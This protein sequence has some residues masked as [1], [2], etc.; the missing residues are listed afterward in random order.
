MPPTVI[1]DNDVPI[2][3]SG[4]SRR[5]IIPSSRLLDSNNGATPELSSHKNAQQ[6][7]Q[8]PSLGTGSSLGADLT[9]T[10]ANAKRNAADANCSSPSSD[11]LAELVGACN[12]T[13]RRKEKHLRRAGEPHSGA[14][15]IGNGNTDETPA[16]RNATTT[17]NEDFLPDID[18]QE[19]LT[20]LPV[21][22]EDK[23]RDVSAFFGKP[24]MHKVKDGKARTV[25]DCE[26]C[27][28]KGYPHQIVSDTSTCRR[29]IAYRHPDAY[30]QWCKANNFESML[31]QDVKERK[32]AAAIANAQQT[33]LDSHLEEIPPYKAVVP[34]TDALF[35]EEWWGVN[36]QQY[37]VWA[38]LA[39]NHLSIMATSV[40]SERAFSAAALTITKR[41]N[42]LKGD[43][44][45]AIQVLRMMYQ[46]DL[47]FREAAPS[48]ALELALDELDEGEENG[49]DS[50]I[51]L[52]EESDVEE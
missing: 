30:R 26:P 23:G 45:E 32:T 25:R 29:H 19:V 44:V 37:P 1:S 5:T 10:L 31:T 34:Y 4:R 24:Y 49:G 9:R 28:K 42:R 38:S 8:P 15:A 51:L 43:I 17:D 39:R 35:R 40:S 48:S 27:K 33:S 3:V 16:S 21:R 14:S 46:R 36:A 52:S 20:P 18:V 50:N 13:T 41:R 47:I 6:T 22:R 7:L 2:I 12:E 11:D